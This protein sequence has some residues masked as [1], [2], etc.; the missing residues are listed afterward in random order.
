MKITTR[1]LSQPLVVMQSFSSIRSDTNPY[2]TQLLDSLPESVSPR[3]FSWKVALVGRFDVLHIHWPE[4]L[5]RGSSSARSL[6]RTIAFGLVLLRIRFTSRRLVRTVHNV[7]PH[8]SITEIQRWMINLS[9]RWTDAWITLADAVP[10][11]ARKPRYVIPIGKSANSEGEP[12][13]NTCR[14]LFFGHIRRYKGVDTLV[15]QFA[16]LNDP[17]ASLHVVGAIRDGAIRAELDP[18]ASADQRVTIRDEYVSEAE[19]HQ[20]IH[21]ARIV[22]LPFEGVTNSS[23]VILALSMGRPVLTCD[24]PAIVELQHEVGPDWLMTYPEELTSRHLQDAIEKWGQAYPEH[25]PCLSGR[26]WPHIGQLHADAYLAA[27][28]T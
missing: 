12:L 23:S 27:V 5:L 15:S 13:G 6:V 21:D 24:A 14:F 16:E 25:A 7:N 22:V 1:G 3:L 9:E 10:T 28:Q 19:L 2:L 8:E 20:A 18:L 17:D 4:N 26:D 11:P